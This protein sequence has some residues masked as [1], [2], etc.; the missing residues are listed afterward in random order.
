MRAVTPRAI[1]A[2]ERARRSADRVLTD[3]LL[4]A[5]DEHPGM[6]ASELGVILRTGAGR[7]ARPPADDEVLRA[8]TATARLRSDDSTPPRWWLPN[9]WPAAG[10][11]PPRPALPSPNLVGTKLYE[12]QRDALAAWADRGRRGVV[13]AVTGTGKTMLGIAAAAE[14]LANRGQVVV[15]V[16]T[17]ELMHQWRTEMARRVAP[18]FRIA[19]LGGGGTATLEDCDVVIAIVNTARACDLKLTR[20]GGLLVADECHRF[21]T[22]MNRFALDGRFE[23]RLG[24]SATYAR[25]DGG[26]LAWLDTYFGP[27]C[28]Q[29]GYRRAAD[30]GI[31]AR[32]SVALVASPLCPDELATYEA[33][34]ATIGRYWRRLV[35]AYGITAQPFSTFLREVIQ[36]AASDDDGR[37][38][39]K[40]YLSALQ[41][42]RRLV[43][44]TPS[45][46]ATL[47]AIAPTMASASRTIVFTSSIAS[48]ERAC[49]L[50]E[51]NGQRAAA[52]HSNMGPDARRAALAAFGNGQLEVICAP[53]VLDEGIDVPEADLAIV[54]G[55]SAT[56]RQMVQRMGRV[57]RRKADGR[58]ARLAIIF[59]PGTIEDPASGAHESFL[60]EATD[61]ADAVRRFEANDSAAA[62]EFLASD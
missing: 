38:T 59:V 27:T 4:G 16:P 17:I 1:G 11:E 54:L 21:G 23:R 37:A 18:G 20:R 10:D 46:L 52:I 61:V 48:S 15:L 40:A 35:N 39:A 6:T 36:L 30:D 13:E 45:K 24:L 8:L 34:T 26:H 51:A 44:D 2:T 50:L 3:D 25:D 43:A 42:R 58:R 60:Q 32:F 57:L 55:A 5:V 12:W 47:A 62:V 41:E 31:T 22:A 56:R 49:A 9:V 14:E 28:F 7:R 29:L 33:L 53:R 19:L